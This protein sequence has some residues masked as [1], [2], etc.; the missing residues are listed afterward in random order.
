M[1]ELMLS[2]F[3]NQIDG[4]EIMPIAHSNPGETAEIRSRVEPRLKEDAAR[5]LAARGLNISEAIRLFLRQVV[6]E[7]GL[8]FELKTPNAKTLAAMRAAD[9]RDLPRFGSVG[10]L[11]DDL[12]KDREE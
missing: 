4:V 5:V 8:P 12:E 7:N 11:F 10:E 3:R 9:S 6:A 2:W 1:G